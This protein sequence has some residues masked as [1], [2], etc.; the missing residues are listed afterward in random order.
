MG[1]H[2][3]WR[4]NKRQYPRKIIAAKI[5][6]ASGKTM[7]FFV[8]GYNIC[9]HYLVLLALGRSC[10]PISV[11]YYWFDLDDTNDIVRYLFRKVRYSWKKIG[12]DFN[13]KN[14]KLLGLGMLLLFFGQPLFFYSRDNFTIKSAG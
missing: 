2:C 3:N 8:R 1:I 7:Q 4:N 12:E 13:P 14:G 9:G 5:W 10:K 6:A 11:L